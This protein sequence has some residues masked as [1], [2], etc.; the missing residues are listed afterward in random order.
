MMSRVSLPV[1][2]RAQCT[3]IQ[4]SPLAPAL[5]PLLLAL[6]PLLLFLLTAFSAPSSRVQAAATET[7]RNP[8]IAGDYPDPSVIR[9]RNEYWGTATSSEWGPP[10]PLLRSSDLVNWEIVGSVFEHR[11]DW[12]VGN[13]WAPEIWEYRGRYFVYYVARKRGGP[14]HL[15][16]ATAA[17]P[18]GP[19]RDH[20]PL[21]GQDAGSID[22]APVLDELGEPYLLWKEDGNSRNQ[23]TPIWAQKLSADGTQLVGSMKELMRNDAPWEG[24]LVE[25]PYVLRRN[26]W[27]YLFY[28]GN[29][30][31]GRRCNYAL[32]VAR[33]RNLLGPWEKYSK[34]PILAAND[35]WKCPGHGTIVTD[36]RGRTYLMYHAYDA[37]TFVYVG[38]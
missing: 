25:G 8:V 7:F 11:P 36:P 9:V 29:A 17:K 26:G 21:I 14:L 23:P 2:R 27:F 35:Q 38:R 30:C 15:A 6:C 12:A 3:R 18:G 19:Y 10:F 22:P 32:G 20:G 5:R 34:N 16:V 31:C 37:Q 4:P 24:N 33:A 28:S 1:A 13:F